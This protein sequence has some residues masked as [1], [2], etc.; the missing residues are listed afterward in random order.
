MNRK[1]AKQAPCIKI[2][3]FTCLD[4]FDFDMCEQQQKL[5]LANKHVKAAMAPWRQRL[6]YTYIAIS[7]VSYIIW[8]AYQKMSKQIL[9]T[10]S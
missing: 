3:K 2:K 4:R 10:I 5:Q 7:W 6:R 9:Q 8:I 1:I